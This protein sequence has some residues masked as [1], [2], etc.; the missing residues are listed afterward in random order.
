[1][2]S[3]QPVSVRLARLLALTEAAAALVGALGREHAQV[4]AGFIDSCLA[5]EGGGAADAR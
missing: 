1:V 5:M 4:Y 2:S 3:T